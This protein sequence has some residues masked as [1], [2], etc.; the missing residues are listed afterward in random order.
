M[1][2]PKII[3]TSTVPTTLDT[4]CE[5]LF[6]EL[7][8]SYD[9]VVVSSPGKALERM[10]QREGITCRAVGMERHIAPLKDLLSLVRLYR[11]FRSERP[12]MVHSM[13]PKA[14][15]LSMMAAWMARVPVRV[16]TFTGLVFPTATGL[17]RR[18][19]MLTD[20][21][22]CRCATHV[23]PE[24]EGVKA[25]LLCY[26]ITRKPMK[27]LGYGNVRGIDLQHYDRTQE[28]ERQGAEIRRELH[29]GASDFVF[30]FVGRVVNDKGIRELV[31]AFSQL[32]TSTPS[33]IHLI[34]VG[35]EEPLLDPIDAETRR[36][37]DCSPRI[38]EVGEQTDVR[39]WYAAANAFVL[40]SY[41]EGF[42]NVVIEAGA[43]G[44]PSI[45]SDVNGA[46]EIIMPERNGVVIP[47]KN[48]T[49]LLEAMRQFVL[50]PERTQRLAATAR[51]MVASRYE[52]SYV[53]DCLKTFYKEVLK[54]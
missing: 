17:T 41:R 43:M 48:A 32:H 14:G 4:F 42:P 16:H 3:R 44:L 50:S 13:T 35:R 28:I 33:A 45:V 27:V 6:R 52:Q 23:I 5:G 47:S 39:P 22:T 8:A 54:A 1:S 40:P 2:R 30:L 53:R 26:G 9:V 46:R 36:S 19:L 20:W 18:V 12:Q 37:I 10:A 49:A 31:R 24:G 25:D 51:P 34:L 21:M 7:S 11:V 29:I 38:H 15:L